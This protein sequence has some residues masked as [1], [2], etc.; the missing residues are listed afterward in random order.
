MHKTIDAWQDFTAAWSGPRN[1]RMTGALARFEF[2]FPPIADVIDEVRRDEA[3]SIKSGRKG[4]TLELDQHDP[5]AFRRR[6]IEAVMEEPFALAHFDLA[7]FD[8]PGRFLSGFGAAVMDRWQDDLGANG[9]E[10]ER[11][12]PILFISGAGSATNYHMDFSHVLAWQVYGTKRFCGLADPDR[13]ADRE[14]R[15]HYTPGAFEKPLAIRE[16]DSL[17]YDMR[18]DDRLWNVLL[19]PHWVEAG[20]E[21]A[22]SINI[23]HGGLRHLGRLSPNEAELEAFR[24]ANPDAAPQRIERNWPRSR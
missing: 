4:R 13:W 16:E 5:D 2:A 21:P 8:A 9:F 24:S 6:P 11:C 1:F 17:C 23:S 18:P 7:R 14:T 15:L 22:M 3:A 12:Y 10:W 19:T 20:D